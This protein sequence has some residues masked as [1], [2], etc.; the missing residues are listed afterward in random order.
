MAM[1]YL[2]T[3]LRRGGEADQGFAD[4]ISGI[5]RARGEDVPMPL[6]TLE[7]SKSHVMN[8][9]HPSMREL[10]ALKNEGKSDAEVAQILNRG[11]GYVK[12][13]SSLLRGVNFLPRESNRGRMRGGRNMQKEQ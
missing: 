7:A 6:D 1:Q 3:E 2:E 12:T 8:N 9:A 4:I 5:R 11:I 10:W 13:V